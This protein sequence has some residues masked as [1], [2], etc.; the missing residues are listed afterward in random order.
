MESRLKT[1]PPITV[2]TVLLHGGADGVDLAKGT[3]SHHQ[4]FTGPYERRVVPGAGHFLP[5]EAPA[6][7]V[8]AVRQLRG[9]GR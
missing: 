7:V 2:P 1:R 9:F 6:A 3:E 8:E 4:F 5:H